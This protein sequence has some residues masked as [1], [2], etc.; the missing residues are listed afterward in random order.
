M[1]I[2]LAVAAVAAMMMSSAGRFVIGGDCTAPPPGRMLWSS[3]RIGRCLAS[4]VLLGGASR[5]G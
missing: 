3:T 1:I 2:W 5:D 4:V